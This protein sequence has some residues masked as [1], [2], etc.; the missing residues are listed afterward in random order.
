MAKL[1]GWLHLADI[2]ES[3]IPGDSR[4]S[5]EEHGEAVPVGM[6]DEAIAYLAPAVENC[7]GL[8]SGNH[9]AHLSKSIGNLSAFLARHAHVPYLTQ[10]AMIQLCH[11]KDKVRWG[12]AHGHLAFTGRGTDD[13][14]EDLN[15]QKRLRRYA[16]SVIDA[17]IITLGHGHRKVI[18]PPVYKHKLTQHGLEALRRP[19]Q[20]TPGWVC[21]APAMLKVYGQCE[22]YAEARLYQAADLGWLEFRVDTD[23]TIPWVRHYNE[24]GK[25]LEEVRPKVL[26]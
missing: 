20:I 24:N 14:R 9:E 19:V 17:D 26:P 25:I 11:G 13:E 7:I 23:C 16:S 21:M 2:A 5:I 8:L 10:T 15:R 12:A 18:A 1:T 4:F 22:T 3:I 6:W